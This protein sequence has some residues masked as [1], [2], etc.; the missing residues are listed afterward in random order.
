MSAYVR[1]ARRRPPRSAIR[2][3]E[4]VTA[5]TRHRVAVDLVDGD[6][7]LDAGAPQRVALRGIAI[8]EL[9][10]S[11]YDGVDTSVNFRHASAEVRDSFPLGSRTC[12]GGSSASV[13]TVTDESWQ[14]V[15]AIL[16]R[17]RAAR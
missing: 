10:C 11:G 14:P 12:T 7:R 2:A 8:V 1:I 5:S 9:P 17:I 15:Q 6:L 3:S 13:A 16:F 4:G